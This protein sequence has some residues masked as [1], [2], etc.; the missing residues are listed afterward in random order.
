MDLDHHNQY[1]R[2]KLPDVTSDMVFFFRPTLYGFRQ[3]VQH[4]SNH[5]ACEI[6]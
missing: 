5:V 3:V 6:N 4:V 1:G 2:T